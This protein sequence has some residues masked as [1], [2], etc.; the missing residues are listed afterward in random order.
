MD[1]ERRNND[2]NFPWWFQFRFGEQF[3]ERQPNG[4]DYLHVD[5]DQCV[6]L[7][8]SYGN[9]DSNRNNGDETDHQLLHGQPNEHKFWFG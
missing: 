6:W 7:D 1:D 5:C 4:D 3:N 9:R 2:F 8:D